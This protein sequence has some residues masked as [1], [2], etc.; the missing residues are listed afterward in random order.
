MGRAVWEN[1]IKYNNEPSVWREIVW[2]VCPRASIGLLIMGVGA[3]CKWS[4]LCWW[5]VVNNRAFTNQ[6][7]ID[8]HTS[9][10]CTHNY[11]DTGHIWHDFQLSSWIFIPGVFLYT[12]YMFTICYLLLH[13]ILF[14]LMRWENK[15]YSARNVD[16]KNFLD[17]KIDIF[18]L[19][20][21]MKFLIG[22]TSKVRIL[23][24]HCNSKQYW[25]LI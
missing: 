23:Y 7:A 18:K 16:V 20:L 9:T 24:S 14:G 10:H 13:K 12:D 2:F 11:L 4:L 17:C 19:I 5:E 15:E 8:V 6:V 21:Q 25:N 1:F 3:M 22:K